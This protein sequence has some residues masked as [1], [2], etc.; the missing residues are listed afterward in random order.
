MKKLFIDYHPKRVRVAMTENGELVEF[1]IER[2]S[3]PKLVGNIYK[4]RVVNVL[5]GMK[6]AFVNIGLE[7][8]AFLYV[9]ES[10]VDRADLAKS[11]L[12]MPQKLKVSAGDDILCQVVKDH[13]GTKGVRIS[14]NVSLPGRLLVIMPQMSYIGISH[15]ITDEDVRA[16]LEKLVAANCPPNTG[17][18]VRTE[19]AKAA[20]EEIVAEMKLL[21]NKW[22]N[23][24]KSYEKTP[25]GTPVYEEG[26]LIFRTI[27]DLLSSDIDEIIVNNE[28]VYRDLNEKLSA[29]YPDKDILTLYEGKDNFL[30]HFNLAGKIDK[31]LKRK[32]V[33]KNG[34]YLIVDRTE[35]LTVIDVNTGRYVGDT[36]LEE[37]VFQTNLTAA[38]EIAKQLRLRNIGGIIVIDF[39]DMEKEE[40][41]KEVVERLHK[42][43]LADRVRTSVPVMTSLG[44]V[45]LTRKKTRSMIDGILLRECPYCHGDSY[46]YSEEFVIMKIREYL[47]NLFNGENPKN[48]LI[49]VHPDVC[50]KIFSLRYLATDCMTL[51]RAKRIYIIP[52]SNM[53]VD[54]F[55]AAYNNESVLTL[56][57]SARMLY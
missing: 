27:R 8:N 36:D 32:V 20:D 15:K 49:T 17:F 14:Q 44:L 22:N 2:A 35:A 43:L 57:S 26:D 28:I 31:L 51:W 19:A 52:E 25:E 54:D 47:V 13:F 10:L 38:E 34:A 16:R 11:P 29:I 5:A 4:G 56:P 7:K 6:A 23:I 3:Q 53:H 24:K 46:V 30:Y 55:S 45:E 50:E 9:G 40:H 21:I 12:A 42:A 33:L 41:Q 39:I 37:T 1:Y 48:V 18:I